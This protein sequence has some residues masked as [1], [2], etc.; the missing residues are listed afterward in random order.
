MTPKTFDFTSFQPSHIKGA[1]RLSMS[2]QWP[3]RPEDWRL[4]ASLSSGV[5]M[6]DG[7]TVVATALVSDFGPVATA[8]MILVDSRH[9]GRGF[10]RHVIDAAMA[11]LPSRNDREWR[12]IA[13]EDGLPLYRK[14]GFAEYGHVSQHQGIVMPE[15]QD[16]PLPE[17]A[18]VTRLDDIAAVDQA[19][20]GMDRRPLL[21]EIF[22]Q[23]QVFVNHRSGRV[24]GYAAL[25]PFGF[26]EVLGPVIAAS[27]ADAK[28]LIEPILASARGRFV[29]LD[30][31][32]EGALPA[33]LT[34]QGLPRVGGGL[35]MRKGAAPP[36]DERL[37]SH[38]LAAQALG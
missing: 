30:V 29:R 21:Q 18:D 31:P 17:P 11:E 12:L 16:I 9:R 2:E 23:G 27:E 10:G 22:R 33:W 5:V 14:M 20:T 4:L 25:R 8:G 26:G 3:H 24:T 34:R 6:L 28:A 1:H 37:A 32:A 7:Q 13:T 15:N 36:T 38:A 35:C 19:G